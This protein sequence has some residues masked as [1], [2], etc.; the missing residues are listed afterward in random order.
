VLARWQPYIRCGSPT[1]HT[2][3]LYADLT[4]ALEPPK[5]TR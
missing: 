5:E 3:R 2:A 4:E 1:R